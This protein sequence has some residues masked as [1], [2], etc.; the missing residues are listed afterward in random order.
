MKRSGG[1]ITQ[2]LNALQRR[3]QGLE[4]EVSENLPLGSTSANIKPEDVSIGD[5]VAIP[6]LNATGTVL[7]LP[8]GKG[9]PTIQAGIIK[10]KILLSQVK[11]SKPKEKKKSIVSSKTDSANRSVKSECDLRGLA[12]DEAL[13]ELDRYLD[14]SIISGLHEVY[15]IHG[16]GTGV[17]RSGIHKHLKNMRQIKNYRLGQYGEGESGVTVVELE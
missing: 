2:S 9:E 15:V 14:M 12:L 4:G 11:L 16:K 5:T 10:M 13:M 1:D 8:D 17:L 3:L 6:H 7:T